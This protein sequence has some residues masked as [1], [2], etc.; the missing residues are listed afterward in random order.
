[1][2][3]SIVAISIIFMRDG[4]RRFTRR[5]WI[6]MAGLRIARRRIGWS[7]FWAAIA[8]SR[9]LEGIAGM[10]WRVLR[11]GSRSE[12]KYEVKMQRRS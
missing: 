8:P 4:V 3:G 10:R 7:I 1:M 9:F 6:I 12:E 5:V 2:G 11:K